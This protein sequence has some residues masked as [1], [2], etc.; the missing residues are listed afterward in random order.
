MIIVDNFLKIRGT[1]TNLYINLPKFFLL[2]VVKLEEKK[3]IIFGFVRW[4]KRIQIL[5]RKYNY[6]ITTGLKRISNF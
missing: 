1:L 6:G 3:Y 4:G 2:R 5:K